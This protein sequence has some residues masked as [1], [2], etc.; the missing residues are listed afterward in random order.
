MKSG[1]RGEGA[2]LRDWHRQC[3][4]TLESTVAHRGGGGVV[5]PHLIHGVIICIGRRYPAKTCQARSPP[6]LRR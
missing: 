6:R 5:L 3:M 4:S 2:G 1:G